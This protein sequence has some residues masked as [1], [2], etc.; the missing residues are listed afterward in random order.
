M[1]APNLTKSELS[2]FEQQLRQQE[3]S[4][5]TVEKYLHDAKQFALWLNKRPVTPQSTAEW[6]DSL[7]Q[8][9][10]APAPSTEKSPPL[11]PCSGC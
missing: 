11:T 2:F 9:G 7:L 4:A 1:N 6:K 8:A 10:Y 5:A 3:C